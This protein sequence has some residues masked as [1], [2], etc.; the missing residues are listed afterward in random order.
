MCHEP[1]SFFFSSK[2]LF[3]R[4]QRDE[5][6]CFQGDHSE[7]RE[8]YMRV[9]LE[10]I[11]QAGTSAWGCR[12]AACSCVFDCKA[13]WNVRPFPVC[14]TAL[15]HWIL[16]HAEHV[17]GSVPSC[18]VD[19]SDHTQWYTLH[20]DSLY[21]PAIHNFHTHTYIYIYVYTYIYIRIYIYIHIMHAR[22]L[23]D[24]GI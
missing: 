6:G 14:Q 7:M 5:S 1:Q 15:G 12:A 16:A 4:V 19:V 22:I 21:I 20:I 24:R 8:I 2:S 18:L 10:S 13:S 17:G 9:N 3:L 11:F 23:Y